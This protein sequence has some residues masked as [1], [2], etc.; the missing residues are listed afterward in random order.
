MQRAI[1]IALSLA[2]V[3]LSAV[4]AFRSP[5]SG[6][7]PT[8]AGAASAAAAPS[9]KTPADAGGAPTDLPSK[10]AAAD[11]DAGSE[12]PA[13]HAPDT[14]DQ[15][16]LPTGAPRHIRFGVILVTYAGAEGAPERGARS[17]VDAV[18]LATKLAEAAKGD[19]HAAVLRGDPGS[20][21]DLGRIDRGVLEPSS[22]AV[23]FAL[24]VG[25]VSG[26][27]DTPRGF[28]IAKR[29]D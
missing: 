19:F 6:S 29:I 12:E 9:A 21:D 18:A 14:A 3:A 28:W 25:E 4:L 8:A 17:K 15:A 2:A 24:P 20:T 13:A 23:L 5:A 26:V 27:I 7:P 16:Q 1:S 11:V 10:P 22:E